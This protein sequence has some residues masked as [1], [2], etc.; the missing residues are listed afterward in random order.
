MA[1]LSAPKSTLRLRL[2]LLVAGTLLPLIVFASG[3]VYLNH[4]RARDAAFERVSEVVRATRLVLDTEMRGVTL[5][6]EVLANAQALQRDDL[7][8]LPRQ[9]RSLSQELSG[10][11]DLARH[12]RWP[13][14]HEHQHLRRRTRSARINR[15]SIEAVFSTGQPDYSDLF[16]GSVTRHPIITVSV[17]VMRGGQVVYEMSFN[18]PLEMFQ[19]IIQQ[20]R[21]R[22]DWTMSIFDRKGVNIARFPNPEQTIG[23]PDRRH[24]SQC[25]WQA[26]RESS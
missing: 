11:V 16:I 7:D 13:A 10:P 17:P 15:R 2:A 20:Q 23:S 3:V 21:P 1:P 18:P 24:C 8:G 6:L 12:P 5:A 4:M 19:H 9:R 22:D 14:D 26:T 25:C